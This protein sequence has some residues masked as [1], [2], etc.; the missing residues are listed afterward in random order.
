MTAVPG[1]PGWYR[2]RVGPI[3]PATYRI[4]VPRARF[5]AQLEVGTAGR[6][7]VS[8]ALP[9]A[10]Q[11]IVRIVDD[12]TKEPVEWGYLDWSPLD[13]SPFAYSR[14]EILFWDRTAQALVGSTA[15]GTGRFE[16]SS[17]AYEFLD[18]PDAPSATHSVHAGR[19]EFDLRVKRRCGVD[20]RLDR[21]AAEVLRGSVR[22]QSTCLAT[23]AREEILWRVTFVAVRDGLARSGLADGDSSPA[24]AA[25]RALGANCF[26]LPT[27]G[28]YRF[29]FPDFP[30]I[31]AFEV[32]VPER[33]F[34]KYEVKGR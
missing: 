1:K 4:T 28:R 2:W 23:G 30:A 18:D 15:S 21:A 6:S 10:A 26:V 19:N 24:A 13:D 3:L 29:S 14:R 31:A 33:E 34:V 16:C 25:V 22:L 5:D 12:A 32:D 8:I 9:E 27:P 7:D 17:I 11:L 20:L